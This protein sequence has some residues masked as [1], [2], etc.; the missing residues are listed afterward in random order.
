MSKVIGKVVDYNGVNGFIVDKGNTR[1]IF[2]NKDLVSKDVKVND[3][4]AFESELFKTVE[5][6]LH[7]ARFI[8]KQ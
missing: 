2:T 7:L 5:V 6:E 8:E 4:V 1:Y 3:I